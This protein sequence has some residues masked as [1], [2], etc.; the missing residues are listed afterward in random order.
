MDASSSFSIASRP[1]V[2]DIVEVGG[3]SPT[4]VTNTF[5]TVHTSANGEATVT[6]VATRPG[7]TDVTAF[8]PG[9]EDASVHKAFG[10]VTL[11][12]RMSTVPR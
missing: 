5:A 8:A 4:K 6:L 3:K 7:D 10:V 11:G 1:A 9:I 2:G 12:R